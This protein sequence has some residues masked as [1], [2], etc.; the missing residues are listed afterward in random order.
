MI[1]KSII[2]LLSGKLKNIV[3]VQK[4]FY[5]FLLSKM[6]KTDHSFYLSE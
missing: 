4:A 6:G 1:L 3:A 2:W 5:D